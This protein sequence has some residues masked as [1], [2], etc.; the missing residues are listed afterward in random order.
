MR[1]YHHYE[2]WEDFRC[3]FYDMPEKI[4]LNKNKSKV[5]ELFNSQS[6]TSFFMKKAINE[7]KYSIEHN[8]TNTHMNRIAYIGQAACCLYAG[9]PNLTTMNTWNELSIDVQKR[10]DKIAY[11]LI[12]EWEQ[13]RKYKNI[14][15][16]GKKKGI[17]MEYQ[18]KL[19]MN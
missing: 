10:S 9:V 12:K 11:L 5:I 16:L 3:G 14:S 15:N 19:Q 18:T 8:L 13:K 17:V 2:L 6:N 1:I 7:W 4:D